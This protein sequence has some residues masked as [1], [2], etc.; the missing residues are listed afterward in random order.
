MIKGRDD[1][2]KEIITSPNNHH[3]F[4]GKLQVQTERVIDS[5]IDLIYEKGYSNPEIAFCE[6]HET[7]FIEYSEY[8]EEFDDDQYNICPRCGRKMTFEDDA[9][10][11]FCI[12]CSKT[13]DTI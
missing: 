8:S 1:D 9:G 5:F 12:D 4:T 10:N 13:D 3:I 6:L 2:T 7:E 11:G